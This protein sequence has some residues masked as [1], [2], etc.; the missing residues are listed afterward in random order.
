MSERLVFKLKRMI[1][2]QAEAALTRPSGKDPFDYGRAC[3]VQAGLRI[4]LA[5]AEADLSSDDED[6][7]TE[8]G[9]SRHAVE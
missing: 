7:D 9:S 4:A 2:E 1:A 8:H 6:E 5:A 3:G